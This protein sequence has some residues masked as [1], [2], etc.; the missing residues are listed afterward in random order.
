MGGEFTYQ[1]KWD[2]KTVLT[3][4]ATAR[5][6]LRRAENGPRA[7]APASGPHP[8]LPRGEPRHV[9]SPAALDGGSG[10]LFFSFVGCWAPGNLS[11]RRE[12]G[13]CFLRGHVFEVVVCRGALKLRRN[14]ILN[15]AL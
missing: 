1:P 10:D 4:T 8:Q 13:V 11:D 15:V 12:R 6:T 7:Q 2:P 9:A 14:F 3:T 5:P